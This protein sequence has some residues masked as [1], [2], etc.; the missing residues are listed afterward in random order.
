MYHT[1]THSALCGTDSSIPFSTPWC[2][3]RDGERIS[4]I[5]HGRRCFGDM[6]LVFVAA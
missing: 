4:K 6:T 2:R 1:L 5:T 3:K